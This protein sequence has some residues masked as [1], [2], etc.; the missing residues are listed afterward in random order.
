LRR[1]DLTEVEKIHSILIERHG[2]SLGVRD[3]TLL[4]SALNRPY[5]TFDNSELYETPISKAAALLESILINHPFIDGNKRIGY[6]LSRL[7]LLENELDYTANLTE[8]YEFI[9]AIS[10]GEMNYESIANWLKAN[11]ARKE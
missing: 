6:V 11:T 4:E 10:K 1:I 3:R 9:I 2:G 5:A 7:I 8:K